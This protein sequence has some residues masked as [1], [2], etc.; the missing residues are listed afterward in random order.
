MLLVSIVRIRIVWWIFLNAAAILFFHRN[1]L[2]ILMT[3]LFYWFSFRINYLVGI[4]FRYRIHSFTIQNFLAILFVVYIWIHG[5]HRSKSVILLLTPLLDT[6][7]ISSLPLLIFLFRHLPLCSFISFATLAW[8]IYKPGLLLLGR[9]IQR[10]LV[11]LLIA[12]RITHFLSK[13]YYY[14]SHI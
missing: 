5:S 3:M 9:K 11:L 10:N 8:R 14:K 7:A 2:S 1:V 6:C 13:M 4:L 12:L